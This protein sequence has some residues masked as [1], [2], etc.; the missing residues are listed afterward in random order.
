MR[1]I[2]AAVAALMLAAPPAAGQESPTGQDLTPDGRGAYTA[3]A[4]AIDQFTTRAAELALEKAQR[5]EVRALAESLLADH[6]R[7]AGELEAAVR[8][9]GVEPPLGML[10]MHWS[11]LRR[12]ERAEGERFDRIFV[13]QQVELHEDAV[14]MHR[15]FAANGDAP[16][17]R[18][19]AEAAVPVA[20]R[21]LDEA[22]RLDQ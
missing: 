12:L 6:R 20:T 14:A 5:P 10:P 8:A 13:E 19:Y 9:A 3:L 22:R 7:A 15:N 17:L 1:T 18:A 21:H 11:Q 2:A 4:G 16:R